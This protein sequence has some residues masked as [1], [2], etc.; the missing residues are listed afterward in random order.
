HPRRGRLRHRLPGDRRAGAAHRRR[1]A[2]HRGGRRAAHPAR[3]QDPLRPQPL[4]RP[5]M[6]AVPHTPL[7]PATLGPDAQRALGSPQSR[8][9]AARGLLPIARP[10]DLLSLLY[11][12]ALDPDE[13]LRAAAAASA[14]ALP[15]PVVRGG[16]ADPDTDPRVLDFFADVLAGAAG[17]TELV[18]SNPSTADETLAAI[19]ARASAAEVD[20]IATNEARLLRAPAV[21]AALYHNPR[22]RMSTVDRVVELAV[23]NGVKVA[24]IP[25]WE[26]IQKVYAPGSRERE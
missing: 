16:L 8:M 22:A 3:P 18:I 1:V 12:V 2:H 17:A 13:A 7:D 10:R 15:D 19:A 20:R 26:E 9:M 4:A 5:R 11:Q 21:I 24:G 6:P 23:R 14:A 25:A